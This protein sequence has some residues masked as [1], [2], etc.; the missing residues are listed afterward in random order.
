MARHSVMVC[1]V[2][3]AVVQLTRAGF[4]DLMKVTGLAELRVVAARPSALSFRLLVALFPAMLLV[5]VEA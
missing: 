3:T 5:A 2:V 4:T 1:I